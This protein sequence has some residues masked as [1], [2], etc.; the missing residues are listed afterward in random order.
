MLI[1][2]L[3]LWQDIRNSITNGSQ[4]TLRVPPIPLISNLW[5]RNSTLTTKTSNNETSSSSTSLEADQSLLLPAPTGTDA[6]TT[7]AMP[8]KTANKNSGTRPIRVT[9]IIYR[10]DTKCWLVSLL[11][12]SSNHAFT[13]WCGG[14]I[15]MD[16]QS[17]KELTYKSTEFPQP[18]STP[19]ACSWD[20]KVQL[21]HNKI[22]K[23][24]CIASGTKTDGWLIDDSLSSLL[25]LVI[26]TLC[27]GKRW[28]RTAVGVWSR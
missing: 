12:L 18:R 8:M 13:D 14:T 21:I 28:A 5:R 26:F 9:L 24:R 10:K 1:L 22:S 6:L 16:L 25:F 17:G 7:Y 3:G 2:P 23:R 19:Y 11:L 4:F 27:T 15:F 20:V